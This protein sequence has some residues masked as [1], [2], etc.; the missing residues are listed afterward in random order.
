MGLVPVLFSLTLFLSSALLFLVEPMFAKMALPLLGGTSAVWTT[1]MV[2]FQ[3]VLLAGYGY[4]HLASSRLGVRWSAVL[5]LG[6][7]L[8]PL[9]VLPISVARSW[10]PPVEANPLPWLLG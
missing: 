3:A 6:L 5:H 2:F 8:V 1:C 10:V 7:L 9:G 4:A